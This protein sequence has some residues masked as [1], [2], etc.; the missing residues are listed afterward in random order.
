MAR[1]IRDALTLDLFDI[2]HPQAPTPGNLDLDVALRY[3]LSDALKHSDLDRHQVAAEMSRLTGR[4]VSKFMLD[5]YT[6]E[7]RADHNFP[8]RYAAAFEAVT[9][10]FCLT[11]LLAKARGCKVLVGDEALLAELGR[12]EQ[13]EVELRQQKA[14]L[15]RYLEARK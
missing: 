15:K 3:A 12:M 1:R 6:A 4:E 10:S 9:G 2:P 13:M 7:S 8:F 5:A 11:H 14:A